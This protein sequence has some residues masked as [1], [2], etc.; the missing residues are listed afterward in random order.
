MGDRSG[1]ALQEFLKGR[2]GMVGRRFGLMIA[3]PGSVASGAWFR[4]CK[5]EEQSRDEGGAWLWVWIDG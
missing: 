1:E 3:W 2:E 5:G 4:L